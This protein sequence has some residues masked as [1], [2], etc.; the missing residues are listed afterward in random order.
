MVTA[1]RPRKIA[2]KNLALAVAPLLTILFVFG[3]SAAS[4]ISSLIK[5]L[6]PIIII[7]GL[8]L[9]IGFNSTYVEVN[10]DKLKLVKFFFVRNNI[11]IDKITS[12]T[13]RAF[14]TMSLD[15]IRIEY[16]TNSGFSG[17]AVLG[18]IGAFGSEQI[19]SILRDITRA[20]P[21]VQIDA[22]TKGLIAG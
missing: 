13:Y 6:L 16:V 19:S 5:G 3:L 15:G 7:L 21:R 1:Y 11:E 12:L 2:F 8:F 18:S 10:G 22:K 9:V 14:G 20:N 4:D 17:S